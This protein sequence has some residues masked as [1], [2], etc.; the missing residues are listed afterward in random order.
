MGAIAVQVLLRVDLDGAGVSA[1]VVAAA[2]APVFVS[3][4]LRSSR[5][6]RRRIL[7][8][9]LSAGGLAVVAAAGLAYAGVQTQRHLPRRRR[10]G[11]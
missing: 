5:Q 10:R 2:V 6:D 11:P 3:A 1:L 9:G 8:I 4:Y 7:V